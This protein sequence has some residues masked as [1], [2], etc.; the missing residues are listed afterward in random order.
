LAFLDESRKEV[1]ELAKAW[2]IA[3][4]SKSMAEA[5][6]ITISNWES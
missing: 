4:Q 1:L 6:Q 2:R 3:R 5:R